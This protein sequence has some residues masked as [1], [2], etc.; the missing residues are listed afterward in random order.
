MLTGFAPWRG[1][2]PM[3]IMMSV[4]GKQFWF[5]TGRNQN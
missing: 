4:A 3:E 5:R 1:K 2:Q